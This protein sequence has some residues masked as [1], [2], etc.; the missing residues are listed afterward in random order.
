VVAVQEVTLIPGDGIG[1]AVVDAARRVLEAAGTSIRW[2]VRDLGRAAGADPLPEASLA[3]IRRTGAALKGPVSLPPGGPSVNVGLKQRLDLFLQVRP[4][5]GVSG[6]PA[7]HDD[8]DVIVMRE[9]T[10]DFYAGVEFAAGSSDAEE[11]LSWLATRGM[12]LPGRSAVSVKAASEVGSRRMLTASY[13]YARRAGRRKVTVVVKTAVLRC[14][15]GLFRAVARDVASG[16]PDLET[17]EMA[18]DLAAAQL[19]Q[20]PADLDV[21]VMPGQ[22]GDILSD[23]ASAVSGGV[24]IAPGAT[25]GTGLAVFEAVHGT[26]PRLA[27]LDRANPIAMILSGAL[28]LRHLGLAETA[29]RVERAVADVLQDGRYLTYDLAS[30]HRAVGTSAAADAVIRQLS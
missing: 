5:R 28:L 24:G 15:D 18:V 17:D 19:A 25:F 4:A 27:G 23:V 3:S 26:A 1:P 10:E 30:G 22:Y 29:G 9:T 6:V 16:Y 8:I 12:R 14:T 11:F 20:H 7:V 13:D 2:D 21:L